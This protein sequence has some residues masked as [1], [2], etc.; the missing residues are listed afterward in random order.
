MS[1]THSVSK[2]YTVYH[3]YC[4]VVYIFCYH[5][6]M[7]YW[8]H[9]HTHNSLTPGGWTER[10]TIT[11]LQVHASLGI[12]R[13]PL[14][15]IHYF[16]PYFPFSILLNTVDSEI[17]FYPGDW[18]SLVGPHCQEISVY[19]NYSLSGN[20]ISV[21]GILWYWKHRITVL[22]LV[23]IMKLFPSSEVASKIEESTWWCAISE[24][25]LLKTP[26]TSLNLLTAGL[27]KQPS[28]Q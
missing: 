22:D 19:F 9:T 15:P 1:R 26:S 2:I 16:L 21:N 3:R 25:W 23:D 20:G 17:C 18:F 11:N 10:A 28:V 7:S 13:V 8:I 24:N 14:K 5:C 6:L 4:S 12:C 27:L